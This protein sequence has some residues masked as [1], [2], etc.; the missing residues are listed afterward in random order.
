LASTKGEV[1][2]KPEPLIPCSTFRVAELLVA[3]F[4]WDAFQETFP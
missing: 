2:T 3:Y 1:Q 4:S